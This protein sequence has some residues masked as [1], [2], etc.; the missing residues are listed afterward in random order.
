M[1]SSSMYV[2]NVL[3]HVWAACLKCHL[4]PFQTPH[5]R[6]PAF[7]NTAQHHPRSF[8]KA[9]QAYLCFWIVHCSHCFGRLVASMFVGCRLQELSWVVGCSHVCVDCWLQ[10]CLWI[11]S[12]NHGC[13]VLMTDLL[14]ARWH[15]WWP[16]QL[17]SSMTCMASEDSKDF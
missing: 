17:W 1:W 9:I 12:C 6:T 11:V 16:I 8:H 4:A 5:P 13:G 3:G 15:P 7:S 14:R 10:P 2:L